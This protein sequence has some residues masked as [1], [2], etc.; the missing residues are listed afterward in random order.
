M[1]RPSSQFANE[2]RGAAAVELAL[3]LPF[4]VF[5]FVVSV[6]YSRIF[7]YTQVVENCARNGALYASDPLAAASNLYSSVQQAALADAGSLS[8][9]PTVNSSSGTDTSG[10]PYVSVTVAW[11]F[12]TISGY[13]GIPSAVNISRTVQMRHAP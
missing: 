1:P 10:N 5:M 4:L 9:Q 11:Q 2:R 13:P 6:D 12:N 7:Y 3:V 8:P